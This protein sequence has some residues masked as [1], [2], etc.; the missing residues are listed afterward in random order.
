MG[1]VSR[2]RKLQKDKPK[3]PSGRHLEPPTWSDDGRVRKEASPM[4]ERDNWLQS[5]KM[6]DAVI[7]RRL[8]IRQ[9]DI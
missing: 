7:V 3:R 1:S 2:S 6:G 4:T 9:S 8:G 5:L